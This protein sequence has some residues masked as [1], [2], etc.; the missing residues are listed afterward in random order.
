MLFYSST[1][2]ENFYYKHRKNTRYWPKYVVF[3]E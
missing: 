1:I 3:L 2:L